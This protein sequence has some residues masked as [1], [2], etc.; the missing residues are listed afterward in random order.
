M[1]A[2]ENPRIALCLS[3]GGL[4]APLFHLGLI[5]A[6]R[7]QVIGG[8]CALTIHEMPMIG[9]DNLEVWMSN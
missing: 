5:K 2:A 8:T 3:G 7:S 4:R 1:E 6:L 9:P